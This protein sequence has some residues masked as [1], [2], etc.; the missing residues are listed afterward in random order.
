MI[1][2]P[3]IEVRDIRVLTKTIF[4]TFEGVELPELSSDKE[5][6]I[7]LAQA[8]TT[9]MS[10]LMN[11]NK[12]SY[13]TTSIDFVLSVKIPSLSVEG[14]RTGTPNIDDKIIEEYIKAITEPSALV[15]LAF[16]DKV[17][18]FQDGHLI[19]SMLHFALII[20]LSH[21]NLATSRNFIVGVLNSHV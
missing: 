14:A 8:I 3:I 17:H 4:E 13:L 15:A 19:L 9:H 1:K 2:E 21:F 7:A 6:N 20:M 5:E 10:R 11:I 18:S 16:K 12:T